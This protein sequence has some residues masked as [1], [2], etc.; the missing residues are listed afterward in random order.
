MEAFRVIVEEDVDNVSDDVKRKNW[1]YSK[2]RH[3][4]KTEKMTVKL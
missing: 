4:I 1:Q 2:L 3:E